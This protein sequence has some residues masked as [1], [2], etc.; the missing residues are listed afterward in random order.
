MDNHGQMPRMERVSNRLARK[1]IR[2]WFRELDNTNALAVNVLIG[3][4]ECGNMLNATISAQ[5][6]T[7]SVT[8]MFFFLHL[9]ARLRVPTRHRNLRGINK[10]TRKHTSN[11]G[12]YRAWPHRCPLSSLRG[13]TRV[14]F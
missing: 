7:K 8:G 1:Q 3:M 13:D 4:E 6:E 10:D 11:F 12:T 2:Q 5:L 14:T 9:L